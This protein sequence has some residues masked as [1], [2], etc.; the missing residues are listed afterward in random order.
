MHA[1][2]LARAFTGREK[3]AKFEGQYHG[4]HDYVLWSTAGVEAASLGS[5]RSPI[6][7]AATSGIPNALSNLIITMPFN[8]FEVLDYTLKQSW[9]DVACIIVEPLLGNV[10]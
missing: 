1:I 4:M 7:V 6:P 5:R 10:G 9:F 3:V 8:D 2:R